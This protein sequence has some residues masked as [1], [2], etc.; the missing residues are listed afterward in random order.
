MTTMHSPHHLSHQRRLVVGPRQMDA[1]ESPPQRI[2]PQPQLTKKNEMSIKTTNPRN[3][4]RNMEVMESTLENMSQVTLIPTLNP[5][6]GKK[7]QTTLSMKFM[8]KKV[9]RILHMI[10]KATGRNIGLIMTNT[11]QM[12]TTTIIITQLNLATI[13][14]YL[15]EGT[16][17]LLGS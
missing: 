5:D 17:L 7:S 12:T 15:V 10:I 2:Q 16:E 1:G 14:I 11:T 3:L 13:L 6:F 8:R 4:P 9:I